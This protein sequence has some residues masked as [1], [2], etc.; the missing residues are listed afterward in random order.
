MLSSRLLKAVKS[1]CTA[2]LMV[3]RAP[4]KS[5]ESQGHV[6]RAIRLVENQYRALVFDVQE[7]TRVEIDS[8][9]AASA[10]I[11][12]HS[13]WL[14]NRYQPHK[15][16]ATSFERLKR[17][18]YRSPILPLFAMVECLIPS[19]R[20]PGEVLVVANGT[21]RTCR[22]MWVGRTEES[23]EHLVV[24]EIG[25]V[26]RARTVRR[27]VENEFSGSDV[28]K[29][30]ATPS[31]LKLDGDDVEVRERWTPTPGCRACESAR[32]NK[33]LVRCEA[34]RYEYRLKYGRNPLVTTR[35]V[36][37]ESETVPEGTAPCGRNEKLFASESGR[38][39][40]QR[41]REAGSPPQI[42]FGAFGPGALEEDEGDRYVSSSDKEKVTADRVR[43]AHRQVR[44]L[45]YVLGT[46]S[47]TRKTLEVLAASLHE[48][49]DWS[50]L[51]RNSSVTALGG[52]Q[53]RGGREPAILKEPP[54]LERQE[55][56]GKYLLLLSDFFRS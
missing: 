15:G 26:V 45:V 11:L 53:A 44:D 8:I 19:D 40:S 7:K 29:L 9:S 13:V 43:V 25:H 3:Q 14:L 18:P 54:G 22:S 16:G 21:P 38:R 31:Y 28:I 42:V 55:T 46:K 41:T 4:V 39:W 23:D 6:E 20:K 37:H 35:R 24:N 27:C 47:V 56:V 52:G 50:G 30:N 12:R 51:L 48:F 1:I 10:W 32:A 36:Y 49:F 17:S 5:H 33:H 34:R 2:D